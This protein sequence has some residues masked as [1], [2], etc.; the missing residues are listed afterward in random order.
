MSRHLPDSADGAVEYAHSLVLLRPA[1]D[2]VAVR[3]VPDGYEVRLAVPDDEPAIATTLTAAFEPTST[4]VQVFDIARVRRELTEA[5]DVDATF[6]AVW[7]GQAVATASSRW[8]PDRF[9]GAGYVHWVGTDP[10]HKRRGLAGALLGEVFAHF[11]KAGR[12]RAVL[13]TEDHRLPALHS[14]LRLGFTPVYEVAGE[15]H[16]PRWSAIFQHLL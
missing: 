13:E 7:Q 1:V 4:Q 16:R 15:D 11:V 3:K 5:P 14:Y 8:V 6:V 12:T 9:P 10:A 2:D